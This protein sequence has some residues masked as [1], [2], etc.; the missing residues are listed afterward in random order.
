MLHSKSGDELKAHTVF[1][2][3]LF[4]FVSALLTGAAVEMWGAFPQD[5]VLSFDKAASSPTGDEP[6]VPL[7]MAFVFHC[8]S[9]ITLLVQIVMTMAWVFSLLVASSV[10]RDHFP[11]FFQQIQYVLS[12]FYTLTEIGLFSFILNVGALFSAQIH[13]MV[14]DV[15]VLRVLGVGFPIVI[16]M[17][18]GFLV[19]Q[20]TSYMGRVAYHGMLLSDKVVVA[21]QQTEDDLDDDSSAES[22][23]L[24]RKAE[25]LLCKS[26]YQT[27][28]NMD[29]DK[30]LD[31]YLTANISRERKRAMLLPP[32]S[33]TRKH[34]FGQA[35][36]VPK[37][38]ATKE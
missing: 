32:P 16:V 23:R 37:F 18:S 13:S 24:A 33:G 20:I 4:V 31:L 11:K 17:T 10:S 14:T 34:L 25:E 26:F 6:F 15:L 12:W 5:Y 35:Y 2:M 27:S 8:L 30:V 21:D 29:E 7:E 22:G 36:G 3:E 1:M 28:K 9:C 38:Q 19:H